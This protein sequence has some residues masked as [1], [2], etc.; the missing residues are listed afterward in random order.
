M[1]LTCNALLVFRKIG[2][3]CD[4][5]HVEVVGCTGGCAIVCPRLKCKICVKSCLSLTT[6]SYLELCL[7]F[8]FLKARAPLLVVEKQNRTTDTMLMSSACF[9]D[10]LIILLPPFFSNRSFCGLESSA[11]VPFHLF[12]GRLS[13][14]WANTVDRSC[15]FPNI[16]ISG[17]LTLTSGL[18]GSFMILVLLKFFV[19]DTFFGLESSAL[20]LFHLILV[21]VCLRTGVIQFIAHVCSQI[22]LYRNF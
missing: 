11:L 9:L 18:F 15:L 14:Y 4:A 2:F 6:S 20:L 8:C 3:S 19:T 16:A 10:L 13:A 1:S 21:V 7:G 5:I 22:L 12:G 17:F